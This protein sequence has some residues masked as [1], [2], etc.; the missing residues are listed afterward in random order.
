MNSKNGILKGLVAVLLTVALLL[1]SAVQF[2]HNFEDH[3]HVACTEQVAHLH[4]AEVKCPICHFHLASF[5]FK[6]E[7]ELAVVAMVLPS[8]EIQEIPSFLLQT[9]PQSNK[10]LRAPPYFLIS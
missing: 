1:P 4:K 3:H 9:T 8:E 2:I 6:I 10:Q 7:E 5:H